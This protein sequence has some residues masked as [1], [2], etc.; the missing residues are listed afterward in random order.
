MGRKN[1]NHWIWHVCH[2]LSAKCLSGFGGD[3]KAGRVVTC[4][5]RRWAEQA[6]THTHNQKRNNNYHVYIRPR[7]LHAHKHTQRNHYML[8]AYVWH[9]KYILLRQKPVQIT[10]VPWSYCPQLIP[11]GL[12]PKTQLSKYVFYHAAIIKLWQRAIANKELCICVHNTMNK[13]IVW[14]LLA[15]RSKGRTHADDAMRTAP[16]RFDED[17]T[18]QTPCRLSFC[19]ISG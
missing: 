2:H 8:H 7:L 13:W 19:L 14:H 18:N 6:H 11:H 5:T 3:D 16:V 17:D 9:N 1:I 15:H 10:Q 12:D 4:D